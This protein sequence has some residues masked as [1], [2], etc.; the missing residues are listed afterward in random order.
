MVAKAQN[1]VAIATL[2]HGDNVS[3]FKGP[4]ALASALAAADEE[5]GDVITLSQGTFTAATITK[6]VSIYGAGFETDNSKGTLLTTISGNL[7][8]GRDDNTTVANVHLEGFYLNGQLNVGG[9][10][11]TGPLDH[12]RVVKVKATSMYAQSTSSNTSF[13]QCIILGSFNCDTAGG[14]SGIYDFNFTNCIMSSGTFRNYKQAGSSIVLD[15]CIFNGYHP[16][17]SNGSPFYNSHNNI[18]RLRNSI[19]IKASGSATPYI[20]PSGSDIKNCIS[21]SDISGFENCYQVA[22]NEI[23][24]DGENGTYS[25]NRTY[26]LNPEL[27]SSWI[28][29][30]NTEIG[31]LG[32]NGWSKVPSTPVVKSMQL[33]VNGSNLNV[34][35]EAETRN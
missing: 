17:A 28:G 7:T 29:N 21:D 15:H 16:G 25:S 8:V 6:P 34:T 26:G 14:A 30:D 33:G 35:Y 4:S 5:G 27:S 10:Y 2:Q 19:Y 18:L 13:D 3:V 1:D 23:F 32:G 24:K 31:I 12:L 9:A 11:G 20:W 22:I